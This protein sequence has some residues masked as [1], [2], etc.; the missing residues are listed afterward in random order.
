[1]SERAARSGGLAGTILVVGALVVGSTGVAA[2][3]SRAAE[4]WNHATQAGPA[5]QSQT[6]LGQAGIAGGNGNGP[7]FGK[8]I[9]LTEPFSP[10][11]TFNDVGAVGDSPGDYGVFRDPVT[12]PRSGKTLGTIDVQCIAAYS[13]QCRG[14]ISLDGRGQIT[15]DGITPLNV[16]PDEF[17]ITGGTGEFVGAGGTLMVTF[18]SED[19][20]SLTIRLDRR[21]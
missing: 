20:A 4:R 12:N 2:A 13:D 21:Q 9:E 11:F 3:Q 19:F 6:S 8:T 16:D 5:V 15:F 14:S 7:K 18:P 10:D 1:M 17:A